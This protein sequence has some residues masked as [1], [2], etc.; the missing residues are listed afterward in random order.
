MVRIAMLYE[1]SGESLKSVA[2]GFRM[3][4]QLHNV[5]QTS[6]YPRR[7]SKMQKH[8]TMNPEQ[9]MKIFP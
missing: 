9:G 6:L 8:Q 7:Q 2:D 5:I 3:V 4:L 1:V